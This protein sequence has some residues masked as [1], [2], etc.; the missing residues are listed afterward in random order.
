MLLLLIACVAAIALRERA[1]GA[2]WASPPAATAITLGALAAIILI[3]DITARREIG[4][5]HV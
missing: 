5:A 2:V 3:T 1:A 4:R